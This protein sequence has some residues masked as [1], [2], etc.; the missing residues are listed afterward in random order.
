[1]DK[2]DLDR[3]MKDGGK[4]LYKTAG[5][6]YRARVICTDR[7]GESYKMPPLIVLIDFSDDPCK[8]KEDIYQFPKEGIIEAVDGKL[9]NLPKV[10]KR[11]LVMTAYDSGDTVTHVFSSKDAAE[12]FISRTENTIAV[13]R[14]EFTEGET[15]FAANYDITECEKGE[16]TWRLI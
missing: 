7:R 14:V 13:K 2:F 1:M 6:V 9:C 15:S 8:P 10:Y 11:Y 16:L 3:A 12:K 4:C 5:N